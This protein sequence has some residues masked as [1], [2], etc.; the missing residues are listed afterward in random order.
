MFED[1][2]IARISRTRG[3]VYINNAVWTTGIFDIIGRRKNTSDVFP[4]IKLVYFFDFANTNSSTATFFLKVT[5]SQTEASCNVS[6]F[7]TSYD[8][9]Q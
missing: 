4:C 3:R 1:A 6:M 5:A 9:S 7:F 8:T 2:N